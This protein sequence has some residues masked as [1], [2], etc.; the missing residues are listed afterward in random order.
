[1]HL[2]EAS[3]KR[4][5]QFQDSIVH[6]EPGLTIVAGGNNSGKSSLL[7][8]LAVWEFCKVATVAQKGR[9]ALYHTSNQGF[10]LGD[11]EFSPI[12]LPSLKHLWTNL[13]TQKGDE[14]PDGYTLLVSCRWLDDASEHELGFSLAL[15]NDRL[16]IKV[17]ITTVSAEV[18]VPVV[19]YLP[20]FAGISAREER[21]YGALRRRRIGEGLAGAVLRNLLLDMREQN[22]R[23]RALL[24][25]EKSKISDPDLR[26]LRETDPWELLQQTLR[27]VFNAELAIAEFDE[28]YNTYIQA[29]VI[30]GDVKGYQLTRYPGYNSR[31]LMVEGS[32][33][34]QWLSVY[35]LAT[36]PDA[37]V[38]LFDEPDAHLHA[39]LQAQLVERLGDL[40]NKLGKQVLLATHSGE[41][42]RSTPPTSIM[43]VRGGGT[44]RYLSEDEQKV[45]LIVGIGSTYAPR[46]E[47]VRDTRR[48]FF[49]EGSSDLSV[50]RALGEIGGLPLPQKVGWWQTPD[51]HRERKVLWRALATEFPG[52]RAYSLRD[53]DDEPQNSVGVNLEDKS[54]PDV[55]G[56]QSRKWKRRYIE[57]YLIEP[58]AIAGATG[59]LVEDVEGILRD[60][61][62]LAIGPTFQ[63][64]DAPAA[65]LDT[66]AKDILSRFGVSAVAVAKTFAAD[67]ICADAL[68]V[69]RQ[70]REFAEG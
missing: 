20:P 28:E 19:A 63:D 9:E 52:T 14:D 35:T 50:L 47:R 56:F 23:S 42:L 69:L 4:F 67:R 6:V 38:L 53:R 2:I 43:E 15:A 32:G 29:S 46:I 30:K 10:G 27:E 1:M 49:Y 11:D 34:L 40:A 60:E 8:A 70:I 59:M 24:R 61:F 16:F 58:T 5:K 37:D 45:G 21:T 22:S 26:Q 41:I 33:F 66:R 25:G 18:E 57:S 62:S 44:F 7:Q 13:R 31:D 65:I 68:E 39:A 48:V 36:S 64:S 3:V 54:F 17:A 51:G 55:D 12:N